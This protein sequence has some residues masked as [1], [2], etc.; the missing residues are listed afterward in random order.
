MDIEIVVA[1][2]DHGIAIVRRG[3]NNHRIPS[4]L[5]NE[6]YKETFDSLK[7]K[8]FDENRETFLR[9]M[10]FAEIRNWLSLE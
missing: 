8:Y 10:S 2:F 9:L 7:Y 6:L 5:E 1:D 4:H 3:T